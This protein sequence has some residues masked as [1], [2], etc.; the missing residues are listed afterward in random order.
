MVVA[1][2]PVCA[3]RYEEM[4]NTTPW[5]DRF[6]SDEQSRADEVGPCNPHG[7]RSKSKK[8][9]RI[10]S[11]DPSSRRSR[12]KRTKR[13]GRR[14]R[15]CAGMPVG[16][17]RGP[18]GP[19]DGRAEPAYSFLPVGWNRAVFRAQ[20]KALESLRLAAEHAEAIFDGSLNHLL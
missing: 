16:E 20:G 18:G 14:S 2:S 5:N 19:A 8:R 6:V 11:L 1:S 3:R 10:F 4:C 17:Q 9:T 15:R 12:I 13:S 7:V